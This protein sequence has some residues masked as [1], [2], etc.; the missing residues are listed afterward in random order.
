MRRPTTLLDGSRRERVLLG[1]LLVLLVVVAPLAAFL[2]DPALAALVTAGPAVVGLLVAYAGAVAPRG[3]AGGRPDARTA[4][5][6]T[7][8]AVSV[9]VAD[10]VAS[11]GD[12]DVRFE[13]RLEVE[14]H[15]AA[16]V[17]VVPGRSSRGRF[18]DQGSLALP[19]RRGGAHPGPH[20][21]SL[22]LQLVV[23][24]PEVAAGLAGCTGRRFGWTGV[25]VVLLAHNLGR[26]VTDELRLAFDLEPFTRTADGGW[27]WT[28]DLLTDD[29]GWGWLAGRSYR[30]LPLPV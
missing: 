3:P 18:R 1:G 19:P 12:G 15:G 25:T 24:A 29:G 9:R 13:L 5:D 20:V 14:N 11:R 6:A 21:G 23:P 4:L 8:P 28:E 17:V 30:D 16:P 26:T 7:A 2:G 27:A 10:V 22:D